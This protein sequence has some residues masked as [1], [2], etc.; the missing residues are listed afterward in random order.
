M[1]TLD[2]WP[3]PYLKVR[4]EFLSVCDAISTPAPFS[5]DKLLE[6]GAAVL[7]VT[8]LNPLN[9]VLDAL[10]DYSQAQLDRAVGERQ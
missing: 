4:S 1:T 9:T 8:V 3:R 5:W 2:L 10:P 7:E 6:R